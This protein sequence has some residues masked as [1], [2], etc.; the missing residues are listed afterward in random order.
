MVGV[1]EE[2]PLVILVLTTEEVSKGDYTGKVRDF[3]NKIIL[4]LKF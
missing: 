3:I 2:E 4:N 1:V